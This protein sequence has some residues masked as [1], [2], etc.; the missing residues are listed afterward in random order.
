[1]EPKGK[2]TDWR[3]WE[4]GAIARRMVGESMAVAV[5]GGKVTVPSC[6]QKAMAEVQHR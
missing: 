1:M 2:A 5:W 4:D 3:V 6:D